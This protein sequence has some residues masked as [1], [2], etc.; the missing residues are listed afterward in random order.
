MRGQ[1][2]GCFE[3]TGVLAP[4]SANPTGESAIGR[5]PFVAQAGIDAAQGGAIVVTGG[6]SSTAGNAGGAVEWTGGTAGTTG[7]GGAVTITAAGG[8]ST[9]GV[10]GQLTLASGSAA[11]GDDIGGEIDIS[12][13]E[14]GPQVGYL[15]PGMV[16]FINNFVFIRPWV[17]LFVT[18]F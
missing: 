3:C 7:I 2:D 14:N 17:S 5:R 9:S 18:D 15:Q 10:G 11:G 1:R 6:T 13:G 12:A 8:G 16:L 4:R